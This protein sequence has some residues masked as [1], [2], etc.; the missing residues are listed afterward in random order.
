MP[1]VQTM[2]SAVIIHKYPSVNKLIL[3]FSKTNFDCRSRRKMM[4]KN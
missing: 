3:T 2:L 4:F 1:L